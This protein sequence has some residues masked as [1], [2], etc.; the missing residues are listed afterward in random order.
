M[1]GRGKKR[2]ETA[3]DRIWV[4]NRHYVGIPFPHYAEHRGGYGIREGHVLVQ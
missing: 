4:R 3:R 1:V 2:R